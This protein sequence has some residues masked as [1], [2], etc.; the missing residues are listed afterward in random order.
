MIDLS[1]LSLPE[2]SSS[3]SG[4][5]SP[6]KH[7]FDPSQPIT[8]APLEPLTASPAGGNTS[9][10]PNSYPSYIPYSPHNIINLSPF[11]TSINFTNSF[12]MSQSQQINDTYS[13]CMTPTTATRQWTQ[14]PPPDNSFISPPLAGSIA[15]Q[16]GLTGLS[17]MFATFNTTS[18]PNASRPITSHSTNSSRPMTTGGFSASSAI[19]SPNR[20][21]SSTLVTLSSPSPMT[22]SFNTYPYPSPHI[23]YPSTPSYVSG[24][25]IFRQ[26]SIPAVS[27]KRI[28]HPSPAETASATGVELTQLPFEHVHEEIP[29]FGSGNMLGR[30]GLNMGMGNRISLG[31]F[32]PMTTGFRPGSGQEFKPPRFKP[33]K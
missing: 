4:N 31:M 9:W 24:R 20:R 2:S 27:E 14:S 7:A 33:T 13:H 15:V 6:S 26:P 32:P 10:A 30:M 25:N 12:Y 18:T 8:I 29:H 11:P 5:F 28:F 16:R 22:P 3:P 19:P 23:S 17:P 1:A 21:R